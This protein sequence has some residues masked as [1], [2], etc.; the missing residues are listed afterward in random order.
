MLYDSNA[1]QEQFMKKLLFVI[2]VFEDSV[3]GIF[4]ITIHLFQ[5]WLK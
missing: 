1:S 4:P 3:F 5:N 2:T